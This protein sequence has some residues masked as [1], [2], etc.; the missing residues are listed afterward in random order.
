VSEFNASFAV[1]S[2]VDSDN[3]IITASSQTSS[4]LVGGA[5][6]KVQKTIKYDAI[7]L[8][9][10]DTG[11]SFGVKATARLSD[12]TSLD[13]ELTDLSTT[14]K[15]D[16]LTNKF[17]H[18][19]T[20]KTA[21]LSGS[22]SFQLNF[23]LSSVNPDVSP[24][25]DLE[26]VAV[27]FFGSKINVPASTDVDYDIDGESIV[28]GSSNVSFTAATN[29]ITIANTSD[30][31]KIRLGAWIKVTA[32]STLNLNKT[33][34][35][36]NIDTTN[37]KL[38]IVGDSLVD[39]ASQSATVTQY[40]SF[41]SEIAN[42]GTAESKYI[43]KQINLQEVASN[44]RVILMAN[45]PTATDIEL[46]YRSGITSSVDKLSDKIWTKKDITY[47][48]STVETEFVEFEYD[49]TDLAEFDAFQFKFVLLSTNT[50]ATPKIK[51]LRLLA[52]A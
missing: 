40:L 33:G 5:A 48:K 14:H 20:N 49:I 30:Y 29:E 41:V 11:K 9:G 1:T 24:I 50:A 42:G 44:F 26:N 21:F 28:V 51:N 3:Y 6:V 47:K 4:D 19:P 36:S 18:T 31:T 46:Y 27:E 15:V 16:L 38:T 39:E 32:G 43:T 37:N 52:Y 2:I 17:V 22:S 25:I 35:I 23:E 45:I 8:E 7:L 13:T 12:A 10:V 34:Y